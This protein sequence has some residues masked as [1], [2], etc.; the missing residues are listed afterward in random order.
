MSNVDI[1][2]FTDGACRGNPGPGGW[3]VIFRYPSHEESLYGAQALTT[4]NQME[5]MAPIMALDALKTPCTVLLT[6]DSQYVHK[7]ITTWLANWK[8]RGWITAAK[9]PVKNRE[10]WQLLDEKAQ[11]HKI[12]WSWVRGHNGH[13][14]NEKADQLA[15]Q[16]IDEW[17]AQKSVSSG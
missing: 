9:Q 17:L 7:G 6:T 15:N 16:A 8:R 3:G 4:N 12:K 1:E 10:L 5:L 2:I 11:R 14:Y 13:P